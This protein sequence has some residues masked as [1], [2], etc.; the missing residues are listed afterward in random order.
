MKAA[1]PPC[2]VALLGL[3][4]AATALA[5]A[6]PAQAKFIRK[7]LGPFGSAEQQSFARPAGLAVDQGTGELY[8]LSGGREKQSLKV[9]ATAGTF[10]LKFEEETTADIAFNAPNRE[11]PGSVQSALEAL[12]SIGAGNVF[13]REGP[14]DATG[15]HPY[16]VEFTGTLAH[17]DFEQLSCENGATPLSGG[18]GCTVTTE[19]DGE[20]VQVTRWNAD[21]T[22]SAFSALG[23][24]AID[25]KGPGEDQTPENN[26]DGGPE[27]APSAAYVAIDESGTASDGDIYVARGGKH[28]LD[29]FAASGKYLG[30]LT[31]FKEG[32]SA[33]GPPKLFSA[34]PTNAICGVTVDEA[35][36]LYLGE[37]TVSDSQAILSIHKYHSSANPVA[38]ADN[39]ANFAVSSLNTTSC[40]LAAG[41]GP[42]AGYVFSSGSESG[43]S[44]G[45]FKLNASTGAEQYAL[46]IK[47]SEGKERNL[48]SVGAIAVDP[49]SGYVLAGTRTEVLEYDASSFKPPLPRLAFQATDFEHEPQG[50]AAD[51]TS[52]DLYVSRRESPQLDAYGPALIVPDVVTEAATDITGTTAT[53]NGTINAALGPNASC[54]FQYTSEAAYLADKAISG[55]DGFAGALSAGCEPAGPFTGPATNAVSAEVTGL[56]PEA[57]YEF[58]LLG[59]NTNGESQGK[60]K[61][62]ETLGKPQVEGGIASEVTTTTAKITGEVNPRGLASTF[63]VQYVTQAEFE[64]SGYAGASTTPEAEAGSGSGFLEVSQELSGLEPLTAYHFRLIASNESGVADPG[65][66]GTFTTFPEAS[67]LPEGRAYEQVSPAVKLGEVF[68]TAGQGFSGTC[69]ACTPGW[70][71][72][73]MPMQVSPDGN[74]ISYEGNPFSKGLASGANEYIGNRSAGGWV[75]TPLSGPEYNEAEDGGLGFKTFSEDLSR[76]VLYQEIPALSPDAPPN[77]PNL[78]LWQAGGALT[79]LI[80]TEPPNRSPG[81]PSQ[82]N[83]NGFRLTYAG[84][85]AGIPFEPPFS[86][87]V[88][89]ANDA[90]TGEVPGIAPEAPAVGPLETDL[91]EWSG[92]QLH[93]VNVLPGNNA[94]APNTVIGSGHLLDAGNGGA[95]NFDHAISDDGSRI[96]W[97]Q[98]PSGQVYVR[99]GAASTTKVPDPGKFLTATPDGSEVLLSNGHIFNLEDESTADLTDGQGGFEGI[100]GTSEDLARVYFVDTKALTPFGEENANG[101]HA[102]EGELNLYLAESGTAT[103]IG[104]LRADDNKLDGSPY[105][106]WRASSGARAAQVSADGRFLAF[107]SAASLTGYDNV[108]PKEGCNG[109]RDRELTTPKACREVFEYDAVQGSLSCSSCNPTGQ[110]PLGGSDLT[111]IESHANPFPQ[112]HNLTDEGQGR[113]FFE[114]RDNLSAADTNGVIQDVYEWRPQ[115]IGGCQLPRGCIDLISGG[116]GPEDSFFIDASPSGKDAFFTTWD[117]LVPTDKDDLMDLYDARAGGGFEFSAQEPCVGEE[118]CRGGASAAA[119]LQSPGTAG[120]SEAVSPV[121][122]GC[123]KGSVK[124]HG[125]CVHKH[126]HRRR[127]AK[128]GRGGVK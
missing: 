105:G 60:A 28:V 21:G 109:F 30:Q 52:G 57:K 10:R 65:E 104:I 48:G 43:E 122:P 80:T 128:H 87:L 13:V 106:D 66:D 9:S 56:N 84:A 98:K 37:T 6:A 100:L 51:A 47:D 14:G 69:K 79:P 127:A 97:S 58:R 120:F 26:L 101:E 103:F 126:K 96:F 116:H 75:T 5:F 8:V 77:Y 68:P 63:A 24:N 91:Y 113:L 42:S 110:A 18:S 76:G 70:A 44:P 115:G 59:E 118:A 124:K 67:G 90:L 72:G 88:F 121:K 89:E 73:R 107:A 23:S 83:G 32:P 46:A 17:T 41:A 1:G 36:D 12:P 94:A 82:G 25:G 61:G 125:R 35:G 85:N 55:H 95:Y 86:H 22:P 33:E 81:S 93:L 64:A 111:L 117:Q 15:S 34:D 40:D 19:Q 27:S 78:Y 3:L 39:I 62:Y 114:S 31:G 29:T 16:V 7:S 102:E 38:N 2:L 108:R 92:G 11:A 99:E 54:H 119:E 49:A 4:V 45:V 50:L 74:A 53:L 123:K 20:P 112:P 71:K